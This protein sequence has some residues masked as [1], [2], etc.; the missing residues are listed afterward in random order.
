MLAV[1]SAA[2]SGVPGLVGRTS[3]VG[4]SLVVFTLFLFELYATGPRLV[5]GLRDL[6]PIDDAYVDRL[7]EVFGQFASNVALG[8]VTTGVVQ[9]GVAALGFWIAGVGSV[10]ALGLASAI[11][12]MVPFVG[13]A[14]LWVPVAVALAVGGMPGR[15]L[16]VAAWSLL[17]TAS[18]DNL[19]RPFI[20]RSSLRVSPILM[21]LSLTGGALVLGAKGLV[22][23]PLALLSFLT[24]FTF[25]RR[26]HLGPRAHGNER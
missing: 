9:G 2:G 19:L 17:L 10:V 8:M 23:G 22:V 15:A 24:L 26:D 20:L 25:Y 3:R 6:L 16:F 18:V 14:V 5:D 21:L 13:S 1:S 12:S 7:F 11:L 4:L